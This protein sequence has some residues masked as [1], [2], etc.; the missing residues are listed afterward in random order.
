[1]LNTL[2]VHNAQNDIFFPIYFSPYFSPSVKCFCL[3]LKT[4]IPWIK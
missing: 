2:I 3:T 1:M 4:G